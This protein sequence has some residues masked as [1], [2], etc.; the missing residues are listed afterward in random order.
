MKKT[1]VVTGICTAL[2]MGV[3]ALGANPVKAYANVNT[4]YTAVIEE[5]KD[6]ASDNI[7]G[8]KKSGFSWVE[9]E[10]K[11]NP[12]RHWF[13]AKQLQAGYQPSIAY[14]EHFNVTDP[15]SEYFCLPDDAFKWIASQP[16]SENYSICLI[17]SSNQYDK[18]GFLTKQIILWNFV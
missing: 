6:N 16:D 7:L 12:R 1:K 15:S 4:Q 5:A 18:N 3:V 8:A 2:L 17:A 11:D 9:R 14:G 10:D 13:D